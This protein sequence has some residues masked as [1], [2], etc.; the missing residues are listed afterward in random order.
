MNF[1]WLKPISILLVTAFLCAV[2]L[3]AQ[4]ISGNA[5]LQGKYV[6]VGLAPYGCWGTTV[7]APALYHPRSD[8]YGDGPHF[9]KLGFVAD[10]DKDGWDKGSPNKYNGDYFLP[11]NPYTG[12]GISIGGQHYLAERAN[13]GLGGKGYLNID[14]GKIASVAVAG[15]SSGG[16]AG[17]S[18]EVG[19]TAVWQTN[20]GALQVRKII[21]VS[22]D[23]AYFSVRTVFTNTGGVDL[24]DLY[25]LEYVNPDNDAGYRDKRSDVEVDANTHNAVV[26]QQPG[27]GVAL[28]TA[29][30]DRTDTYL[31]LGS[32]DCRSKVFRGKAGFLQIQDAMNAF[33]CYA[34]GDA[35]LQSGRDARSGNSL[36]GIDFALGSL[37]AGDSTAVSF[38]YI[39]SEK[40]LVDALDATE[41]SFVYK[42]QLYFS[43]STI[44]ACPGDAVSLALSNGEGLNWSWSP[45][46]GLD[47]TTGSDVTV[48]VGD[49]PVVCTAT[50]TGELGCG[51]AVRQVSITVS[52]DVPPPPVVT[53]PLDYCLFE[54]V[55]PLSAAGNGLLWFSQADGGIG[56]AEAPVPS[57]AAVGATAYYVRQYSATGCASAAASITV[58][59]HGVVKPSIVIVPENPSI[60]AGESLRFTA[61]AVNGGDDPVFE[62][63]KNGIATGDSGPAFMASDLQDGDRISC[64]L[65]SHAVC[66]S[67]AEVESAISAVSVGSGYQMPLG[68]T[69][70]GD[71]HNDCF[72]LRRGWSVTGFSLQVYNR[73]GVRV[74][75]TQ[76]PGGC[77]DGT[78]RGI[79]QPTGTYVY[80]IRGQGSCGVIDQRGTLT[81]IR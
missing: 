66:A 78:Y 47:R 25:Y 20:I 74:F 81:L 34:G 56:M 42:G 24:N 53:S 49:L 22:N 72:G 71:G 57:T 52:P 10:A 67:P 62:W 59:V 5:F 46:E 9:R 4:L 29:G 44:L 15:A 21:T 14:G 48:Q 51:L 6:E 11:A 26:Y 8:M 63:R 41:P 61:S 13:N 3:P 36:M 80:F 73:Y 1:Y 32:K 58:N 39:L 54:K 23:K 28:V 55:P 7:D 27:D 30:G 45:I 18:G 43:G 68:F 64:V 19:A 60:C 35:V 75:E 76:D 16:P 70:N 12:W 40:D 79:A 31:G 37:V 65:Y 17:A 38:V 50:G 77:W 69:P 2:R 33:S